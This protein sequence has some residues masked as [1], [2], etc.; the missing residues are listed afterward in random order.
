MNLQNKS[1]IKDKSQTSDFNN[2][3]KTKYFLPIIIIDNL[4]FYDSREIKYDK[5]ITDKN[6]KIFK[7]KIDNINAIVL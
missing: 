5:S 3:Q 6:E 1:I 2:Y 4:G 7:N